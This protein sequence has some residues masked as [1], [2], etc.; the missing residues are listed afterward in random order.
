MA[1]RGE[2]GAMLPPYTVYV[3]VNNAGNSAKFSSK[4]RAA[5]TKALVCGVM[6]VA[7]I[8]LLMGGGGDNAAALA[9]R[10]SGSARMSQL[11]VMEAEYAQREMLHRVVKDAMAGC[12]EEAKTLAA[13]IATRAHALSLAQSP[14]TV[15]AEDCTRKTTYAT[16]LEQFNSLHAN[17]TADKASR[18]ALNTQ[19]ETDKN[20]SYNAWLQ[21]EATFRN[22]QSTKKSADDAAT[23]ARGELQKYTAAVEAAKTH[24]Q[25]N[26]EPLAQEETALGVQKAMIGSITEMV[27]GLSTTATASQQSDLLRQVKANIA[28][29][30]ASSASLPAGSDKQLAQLEATSQALEESDSAIDPATLAEALKILAELTTSIDTRL[31][32]IK[33]ATT[34]ANTELSTNEAAK[35][36][37]Q[38]DVVELSNQA[39][40]QN[41][42]MQSA[43]LQRSHLEGVYAV[44][45][46]VYEDDATS[47][48]VDNA[49]YTSELAAI[50][51]VISK[52]QEIIT[53]CAAPA[54]AAPAP[55]DKGG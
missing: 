49:Q 13:H 6:S 23:Y 39:D 29:L 1:G 44:K 12:P 42:D 52:V 2:H 30:K 18:I 28:N 7:V 43:D 9:E 46:K 41:S 40:K 27:K 51:T 36:K 31:T 47:F 45:K 38:I 20:N 37:W 4:W 48:A 33:T 53:A 55:A 50:S 16:I 21:S 26:V 11:S 17:I 34:Q 5:A 10:E 15:L 3:D 35:H 25:N 8:A 54:P 24:L 19:L 32:E 22:A 14:T